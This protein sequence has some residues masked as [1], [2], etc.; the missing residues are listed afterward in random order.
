MIAL[1]QP[2]AR[3]FPLAAERATGA[4]AAYS[5]WPPSERTSRNAAPRAAQ[6]GSPHRPTAPWHIGSPVQGGV[7]RPPR[8][9]ASTPRGCGALRGHQVFMYII[10]GRHRERESPIAPSR[11]GSPVQGVV[12]LAVTGVDVVVTSGRDGR[13]RVSGKE[14]SAH[15]VGSHGQGK[16]AQKHARSNNAPPFMYGP[17]YCLTA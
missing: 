9:P 7:V 17:C 10:A 4:I 11:L 14:G 16:A 6:A 13:A 1:G 15:N 8:S 5:W 12:R 2:R 3:K